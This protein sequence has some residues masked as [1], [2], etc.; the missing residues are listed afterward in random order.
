MDDDEYKEDMD[1]KKEASSSDLVRACS[2]I[3]TYSYI[4]MHEFI[5]N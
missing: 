4:A 5:M 2:L 1:K 3:I